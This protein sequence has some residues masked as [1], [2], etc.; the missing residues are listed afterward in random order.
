MPGSYG[1]T[2]FDFANSILNLILLWMF[3]VLTGLLGLGICNPSSKSKSLLSPRGVTAQGPLPLFLS[4][5]VILHSAKAAL[6]P[7]RI[8][9]KWPGSYLLQGRKVIVE[10]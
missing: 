1:K 9:H 6:K 3:H 2:M 7:T 8:L 4:L 10:I 5:P